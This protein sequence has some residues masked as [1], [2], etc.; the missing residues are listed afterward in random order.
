MPYAI[1]DK[2]SNKMDF[3]KDKF[4]DKAFV[5]CEEI[6][7]HGIMHDKSDYFVGISDAENSS[8]DKVQFMD[9][10]LNGEMVHPAFSQNV[11]NVFLDIARGNAE[12]LSEND[13]AIVAELIKKGYVVKD[14]NGIK[15]N[16][17]VF[18]EELAKKIYGI[19]DG[20]INEISEDTDTLSDIVAG[21]LKNHIPSHLK[22]QAKNM[23]YLR[24][25]EGAIA[26][27]VA[28][29]VEDRYLLP[30]RGDSLISTT[31]VVLK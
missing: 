20:V 16:T 26:A 30:Y 22:K 19:L 6:S 1:A 27:A 15:V 24:L 4:G 5:W 13:K 31:Y 10:P 17:P 18:T 29:L 28:K 23:S 11:A 8:G 3:L 7:E 2:F 21:V 14:G 25:F 12:N 9:F